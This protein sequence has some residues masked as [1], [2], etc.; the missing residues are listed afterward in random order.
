MTVLQG[1][2]TNTLIRAF[3]QRSGNPPAQRQQR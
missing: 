3:S 2:T 1:P